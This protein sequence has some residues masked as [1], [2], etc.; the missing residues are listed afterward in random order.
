MF[1]WI[2]DVFR[3]SA[4]ELGFDEDLINNP[5]WRNVEK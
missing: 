5:Y 3:H 2:D 1:R 4:W